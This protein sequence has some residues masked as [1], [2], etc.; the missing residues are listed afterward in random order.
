MVTFSAIALVSNKDDASVLGKALE[1]LTPAPNGVGIFEVDEISG[2]WEVSGF[3]LEQPN[4]L[5]LDLLEACFSVK[6]IITKIP[7]ENWVN[8]VQRDLKPVREEPFVV[9]SGYYAD[10]IPLNKISVLVEAAMAFGTGH[11]PTTLLCLRAVGL[12]DRINYGPKCIADIGC[13][14]GILSIAASKLF[15]GQTIASDIDCIAVKT[16]KKNIMANGLGG[17][18][19][20]YK[21]NAFN[22]YSINLTRPFDLIFANILAVPLKRLVLP[23]KRNSKAG[24]FIV[25]SGILKRQANL[26]ET[27]YFCNGYLRVKKIELGEWVCLIMKNFCRSRKKNNL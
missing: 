22:H 27:I 21:A 2:D 26:V 8:K 18:V 19:K 24:G 17:S 7:E 1:K 4:S 9:S 16:A 10:N 25:L 6:F 12:L 3:F 23:I 11:H 13:G 14:T 20:V 15:R 5:Q